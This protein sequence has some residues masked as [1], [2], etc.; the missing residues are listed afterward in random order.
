MKQFQNQ[1]ISAWSL[2]GLRCLSVY[3][4]DA[5]WNLVYWHVVCIVDIGY[6]ILSIALY[7]WSCII[8]NTIIP[9]M[10]EDIYGQCWMFVHLIIYSLNNHIIMMSQW[11]DYP[12]QYPWVIF[13]DIFSEYYQYFIKNRIS[14]YLLSTILKFLIYYHIQIITGGSIAIIQVIDNSSFSYHTRVSVKKICWTIIHE[15][16]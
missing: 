11:L 7:L 10:D 2:L 3:D 15:W 13:I 6:P 9:D 16:H 8:V 12:Y 5:V 4:T 14:T 1:P